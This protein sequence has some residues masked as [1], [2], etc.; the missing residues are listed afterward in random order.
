MDD[1]VVVMVIVCGL[2]GYLL[3]T[4][5]DKVDVL[6]KQIEAQKIQLETTDKLIDKLRNF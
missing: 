5:N 4:S 1:K 2:M 3:W 6:Q